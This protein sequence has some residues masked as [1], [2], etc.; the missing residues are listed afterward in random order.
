MHRSCVPNRAANSRSPAIRS[1]FIDRLCYPKARWSARTFGEPALP[2]QGNKVN[3]E[4]SQAATIICVDQTKFKQIMLN[5]LS[6]GAQ[7]N[8]VKF[9]EPR[10]RILIGP[11]VDSRGDLVISIKDT[12]V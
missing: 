8:G 2:R 10:G 11:D 1:P 6:N 9:T 4:L 3:C 5:L 7:S 12:G